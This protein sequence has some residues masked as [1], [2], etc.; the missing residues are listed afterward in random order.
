MPPVTPPSRSKPFSS[1]AE[2][3]RGR[4]VADFFGD[5]LEGALA[6][7]HADGGDIATLDEVRQL[8][9]LRARRVHRRIDSAVGSV[10][11]I[12]RGGQLVSYAAPVIS[13]DGS[14]PQR[15]RAFPS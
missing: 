9:V 2:P 10:A 1:E 12:S 13:T 4:S 14:L 7:V 15:S 11:G 6:L 5:A 3:T 8:L